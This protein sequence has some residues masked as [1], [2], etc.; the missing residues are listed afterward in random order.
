MDDF[1][2]DGWW[3]DQN[4]LD[5]LRRCVEKRPNQTA[6]VGHRAGRA[7]TVD[8]AEL[9]LLT[10]RTARGLLD[11]G[12]RPGEFV[13]VQLPNVME[14]LP[15]TLACVRIGARVAA[16]HVVY[17]RRELEFMARTTGMRVFVTVARL[18]DHR[19]AQTVRELPSIEHTVVVGGDGPA[20]T[21]S[22]EEHL[23]GADG[24]P[25]GPELGPDEPFLIMFTSG[26]SGEPKGALHSQNTLYAAIRGYQDALGLD[27]GLVKLTPHSVTHYVGLV[28]GLLTPL[29]LGGT[30]VV[31]D[32]WDPAG[33]LDLIERHRVTMLYI[34]PNFLREIL[35]EQCARPR[36]VSTL[37]HVVSGSA[38]VPPLLPEQV[39]EAFGVRV[40]SLWGMTEN[41]PVTMTRPDDPADWAAH[42]D[43]RPI[44]GMKTLIKPVH[45]GAGTLWVR[46]PSQCLTY[47]RREELY[48]EELDEGWFNTG[49]LARDDGRGGIRIAGRA[50]DII[51]HE[52]INVP[53]ADVE[54]VLDRH[55]GVADVA[56]IGIPDAAV[57]ERVCAVVVPAGEP[58]TLDELREHLREA[59]VSDWHWPERL[60]LVEAL[61]RTATGKVRKVE[62]RTRYGAE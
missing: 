1:R 19:P 6:L 27:A 13:G 54:G 2:H 11:L 59:G 29:T 10:D 58:P 14:M 33:Y 4:F 50:K 48:A 28:Q 3:R 35:R 44:G 21:L 16:M 61:P 20:G 49:D 40:H 7:R 8:Y 46:G 24:A 17:R 60:E 15:L 62:L 52:G 30:A 45:D 22:F 56:L 36:D 47:H 25:G 53:V 34:A 55:P 9:S 43:G 32:E 38:P 26:T 41:G 37:R 12:V 18:G 57:D 51:I 23:L 39:R 42:S 31:A 5:D